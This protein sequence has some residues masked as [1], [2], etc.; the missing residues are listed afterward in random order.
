MRLPTNAD[1]SVDEA[2][3]IGMIRYAVDHEVTYFDTAFMY[4]GGASER[5]LG[6]ALKDGYRQR[7]RLVTKLPGT[8]YDDPEACLDEQLAKLQTDHLDVYLLH[9]LNA[10]R[11]P[12]ASQE[13]L[14]FLDRMKEKGKILN[15]GFSFHDGPRLFKEIIDAYS[16]E[17]CQIQ[18]NFVDTVYQAGLEGLQYAAD[19]DIAVVV[20]EP[21][22]GGLLADSVPE[23]AR[24][25]WRNGNADRTPVEWALR[26]LADMPAVTVV[27]SG[28][29]TM[30][31]LKENI[32]IFRHPLTGAMSDPEKEV[33]T[34]VKSVY[35]HRVAIGC[36]A[37]NY[38]MP[39]DYG[40]N[41]PQV[42][43]F[44]NVVALGG[45]LARA[46]GSYKRMLV[47][48]EADAT[49]CTE[50]GECEEACPQELAIIQGLKDAHAV[51]G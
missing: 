28:V 43:R 31:Q 20:M 29:S 6:K 39:C 19:R 30:D 48:Q 22:K 3:A 8:R 46:R 23:E 32:A 2:E 45:D 40:V 24:E 1:G 14:G 38:C 26:W 44:H 47:N 13:L 42:F 7:V 41:I 12:R 49:R 27:L 37:C 33:V 15:A 11:W 51:L 35:D 17:A 5:V 18:L 36:T 25:L 50:C 4:H 21:L 9:G 10:R 16:W 34:A